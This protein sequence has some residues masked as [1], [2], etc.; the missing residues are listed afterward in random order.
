MNE[1][2]N[3]VV[4][5]FEL[6]TQQVSVVAAALLVEELPLLR[7]VR[8]IRVSQSFAPLSACLLWRAREPAI[9]DSGQP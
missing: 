6:A 3:R 7:V 5:L 9:C 4:E 8:A 1:R 2:W